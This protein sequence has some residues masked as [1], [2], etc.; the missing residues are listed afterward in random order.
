MINIY[1]MHKYLLLWG[2]K[3]EKRNFISCEIQYNAISIFIIIK[4]VKSQK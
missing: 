1:N 3:S 4:V 2:L